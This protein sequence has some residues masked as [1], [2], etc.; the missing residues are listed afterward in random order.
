MGLKRRSHKRGKEVEISCMIF[1]LNLKFHDIF[2][3][4]FCDMTLTCMAD[5]VGWNPGPS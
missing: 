2:V 3:L 4:Q 1:D 5:G